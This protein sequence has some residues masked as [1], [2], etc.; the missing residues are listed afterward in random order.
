[1]FTDLPEEFVAHMHEL[2]GDDFEQYKESFNEERHYG[3]RVNNNKISTDEF[4]KLNPF[5]L[6]QVPWINNGFYIDKTTEAGKHPY[7]AA[8]LYYLQEPS[9]MTPASRLNVKPGDRVL[10]LCAAPGGKATELGAKLKGEGILVANDVSSSRARALLKN[11]ELAGISNAYVTVETPERLAAQFPEFFDKILIDAPCF[12]EGMFR[13]TPL[14]IRYWKEKGPEFYSALQ[15]QIVT[16][17]LKMLRPGG[18]LVYSTCTFNEQENEETVQ[19]MLNLDDSLSLSDMDWYEGFTKGIGT[20]MEKCARL[21]PHKMKGEGHFVAHFHKAG[22]D[23]Y[24]KDQK[25]STVKG[26]D[27]K[28]IDEFI[29]QTGLNLPLDGL[30]NIKGKVVIMHDLMNQRLRGLRYMRCGLLAGELKKNRFEPS[31][32]FAMALSSNQLE[33]VVNLDLSDE[34]CT[35]YLKGE[36]L[37]ISGKKGWTLVCVDGYPL[38]WAK[39]TGTSLKNKYLPGWIAN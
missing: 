21:Y 28:L 2:L 10:D 37:P 15:K 24:V 19:Y 34:N 20:N 14:V 39:Q 18:E 31:Q 27:K 13:K 8:G 38:G 4:I 32:A 12:G 9:A 7:Y 35:R 3:L 6:Q 5:G 17:A 26:E 33:S 29:N 1:M 16:E 22:N 23:L 30:T 36:T 11:I 25:K